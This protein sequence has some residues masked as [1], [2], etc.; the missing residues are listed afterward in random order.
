MVVIA[1][2]WGFRLA[3]LPAD[4]PIPPPRRLYYDW[5]FKFPKFRKAVYPP[6]I[7]GMQAPMGVFILGFTG[8]GCI[9]V[10]AMQLAHLF[11][12]FP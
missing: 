7:E 6:E 4:S 11:P 10:G 8:F 3:R 5:T 2:A 12:K 9:V 1:V